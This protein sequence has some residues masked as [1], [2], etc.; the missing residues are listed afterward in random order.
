MPLEDDLKDEF[1]HDT[2]EE[3]YELEP[4]DLAFL[5]AQEVH[6]EATST[7]TR[8]TSP[9]SVNV[10]P[11][12]ER[13]EI[14][15]LNTARN[16]PPELTSRIEPT[17]RCKPIKVRKFVDDNVQIEKLHMKK[18]NTYILNNVHF[19]KLRVVKSERMFRHIASRANKKGLRVNAAKT[20]LLLISASN[21]Y[22]ARAHLYDAEN[23]RVDCSKELKALGFIFNSKGDV[24]T[25]VER[26]SNKFRHKV[27]T[28][29]HL[30]KNGFEE[31]EL[32]RVYKSH[33]RPT[34]EYSAPIYHPMLNKDQTTNIER[35]QPCG[36]T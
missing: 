28:L 34:I 18:Q 5:D 13:P 33:I 27:W 1:D 20:N 23:V 25:Q 2:E 14:V 19:K 21:S 4:G 24:S 29:R 6:G 8:N 36:P 9:P 15:I 30:R 31:S 11:I 10:S 26:L 7:P 17:W 32:L 35:L 12:C 3:I 22:E 16:V